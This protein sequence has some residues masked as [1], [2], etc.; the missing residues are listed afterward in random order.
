MQLATHG[1]VIVALQIETRTVVN[2]RHTNLNRNYCLSYCTYVQCTDFERRVFWQYRKLL[3]QIERI[4]MFSSGPWVWIWVLVHIQ[5][6]AEQAVTYASNASFIAVSLPRNQPFYY[7]WD[8]VSRVFELRTKE[9][10][11]DAAS[12]RKNFHTAPP[13]LPF[14]S[15]SQQQLQ[16]MLVLELLQDKSEGY[17]VDLAANDWSHLS[18]SFVL[19]YYNRWRGVCIEP[20]P[21]YLVGL[22]ANRKCTIFVNPVSSANGDRIK[23]NFGGVYGGIVG[24]DFDNKNAVHDS[25]DMYTV[26]L[27]SILDLVQAPQVSWSDDDD[28]TFMEYELVSSHR[29]RLLLRADNCLRS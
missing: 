18:N 25:V 16:D 4:S 3:S 28:A 1:V 2:D 15:H 27:E 14:K 10:P 11:T 29:D 5:S 26:T 19:E 12:L 7:F 6:S 21:Q 13:S 24:N 17:F 20:D 23:F 8:H 22:L 9:L